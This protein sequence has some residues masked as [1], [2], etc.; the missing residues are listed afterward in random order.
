MVTP[1]MPLRKISLSITVLPETVS[2]GTSV[3]MTT[4]APEDLGGVPFSTSQLCAIQ[5]S[6]TPNLL[7]PAMIMPQPPG[8]WLATF[9][10]MM[11][12]LVDPTSSATRNPPPWLNFDT[13]WE[14]R[15]NDVPLKSTPTS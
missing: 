15:E 13:L 9:Q 4:P 14:A 1:A 7:C 12:F 11:S 3:A 10:L 6:R 8:L 5:L 2:P